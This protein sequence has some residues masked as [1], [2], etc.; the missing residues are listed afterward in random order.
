MPS[1]RY[2]V[3]PRD[4]PP[5]IAARALGLTLEAFIEKLP[6]LLRRKFPPADPTTGKYDLRAIDR[7]Q[8]ARHPRLLGESVGAAADPNPNSRG[9]RVGPI[10]PAAKID[11]DQTEPVAAVSS[12][13]RNRSQ[14]TWGFYMEITDPDVIAKYKAAGFHFYAD[15]EWESLVRNEPMRKRETKA[16]GGYFR[17]N[18]ELVDVN[19]AGP[20]ITRR[21]V[22]RGYIEFAKN[23]RNDQKFYRIT[24]AGEAEWLRIGA[25]EMGRR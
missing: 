9:K 3:T 25:G 5:A 4:A 22:A 17:A 7:W 6:E 12:K 13:K 1:I 19:G 14:G 15:G 24:P 20:Q 18:G 23:G 11:S 21:L 8:D 10:G 2:H 16:L